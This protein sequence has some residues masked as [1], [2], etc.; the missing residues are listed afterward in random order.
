MAPGGGER[1]V[2]D[3]VGVAGQDSR[4]RARGLVDVAGAP[5]VQL[6]LG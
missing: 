4:R 3:L 2:V 6:A 1:D 5:V